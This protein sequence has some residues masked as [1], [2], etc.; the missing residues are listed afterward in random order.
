M[1]LIDEGLLGFPEGIGPIF[2]K[3]L[4][5]PLLKLVPGDIHKD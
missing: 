3:P 2:F 5:Q 1:D 4:L